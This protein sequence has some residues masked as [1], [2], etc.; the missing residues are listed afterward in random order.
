MISKKNAAYRKSV[1]AF[2]EACGFLPG[3]VDSPVRAFGGVDCDPL[4]IDR[5]L[6]S[7][8]YDIDGNEYI[9]Y[10]GSW[11]P[12]ILGHAHPWVL[13]AVQAAAGKGT[14][15]GAPTLAETE[16]AKRIVAAFDSIEK[17]RL[18]SSGTEAVMTAIR[19]ARAYTKK[20]LIVKMIGCYHGHSDC[21]LVAA[22]S[23]LAEN[24]TPSSAG[25][26]AEIAGLT[27]AL[28]YNDIEAVKAA[29]GKHDGRIAAV[30]VEPVAAN[31]GVVPPAEGYLQVLRDLCNQNGSL[32]IFD[33][34]ITGFR[35]ALGG[36]Q[37]L[38]GINADITCLGKI[39]GGG[40]P[41]A[42]FGGRADIMDMLAPIGPV[43]QAGTLSGNPLATAAANTM[44]E[45]LRQ[46]DC[47]DKLESSAALLEAGLAQTAKDAGVP[48]T[49]NRVGSIMSCFFTDKLVKNFADVQSSNIKQFKRFFS[50]MLAQRIYLAPSAY[51]AMFVSLAHTRQD[52]DKTIEAVR[53]SMRKIG[54]E[55]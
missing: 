25:V 27:I 39:M 14:S 24:A 16:L 31:M 5:A 54:S 35:V 18:V 6:G 32:L 4:F 12:M 50:E 41:A 40:L 29:F 49:I 9:D 34:V 42:A 48:V 17:V 55:R 2:A 36:A 45:I 28:P 19:L 33:E 1:E 22:G 3:G 30:L 38:F 10:V 46:D 8:I 53:N 21:L 13:E 44:L 51:E 26:P 52:I 37:E 20:D 11:G 15:F 7:K 43:Y 23:G 47:Y